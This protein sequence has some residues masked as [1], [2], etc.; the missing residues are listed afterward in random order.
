MGRMTTKRRSNAG[1]S[2]PNSIDP[3]YALY[4]DQSQVLPLPL[5]TQHVSRIFAERSAVA[6]RGW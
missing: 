6:N 4:A 2:Y 3:V 5:C 1:G